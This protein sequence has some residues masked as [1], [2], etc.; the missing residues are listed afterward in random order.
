MNKYLLFIFF[1]LFNSKNIGQGINNFSI[2]GNLILN[3]QTFQ[4]D[5]QIGAEKEILI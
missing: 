1:I 5:L 2:N 4:E 3:G